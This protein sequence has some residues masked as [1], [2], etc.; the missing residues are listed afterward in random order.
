MLYWQAQSACMTTSSTTPATK[1]DIAKLYR[2]QERWKDDILHA[3]GQWKDEILHAQ[4]QWK[5]E[6]FHKMDQWK[7]EIVL[8]FDVTAEQFRCDLRTINLEKMGDHE[9][10]IIC[11]ELQ[12]GLRKA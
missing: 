10:R 7:E 12:T 5:D 1:K 6:I 2:A 11:L 4:G 3:Q 8:H 9:Q